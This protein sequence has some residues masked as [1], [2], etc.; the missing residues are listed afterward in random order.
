MSNPTTVKVEDLKVSDNIYRDG[1]LYTV[2]ELTPE[3]D[4]VNVRVISPRRMEDLG[5]PVVDHFYWNKRRPISV[6]K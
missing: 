5:F 3:G 1:Y 6:Y 2:A 4:Y